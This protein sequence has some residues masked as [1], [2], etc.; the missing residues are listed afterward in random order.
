VGSFIGA[1]PNGR[2]AWDPVAEA[3]SPAHGCE[4]NGPTASIQSL[5]KLDH[6]IAANGTQYNQ[7]YHPNT[8]AGQKGLESLADLI[9]TYFEKGG[10]HIQFNVVSKETLQKAQK[11]PEKYRHVVVRVAG[12]TAFF[13]DLPKASQDDVIDRT[14]MSFG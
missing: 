6:T 14:E 11:S 9:Q 12:Y 5:A 3:C 2:R 1:T 7:K 4:L 10:Y 13:I 8:L